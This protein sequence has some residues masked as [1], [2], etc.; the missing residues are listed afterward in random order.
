MYL[1]KIPRILSFFFKDVVFYIKESEKIYLTFDDGPFQ[2]TTP[3]ILE[4]LKALNIKAT[5]FCSGKQ[6]NKHFQLFQKI[7]SDGHCIG[8]HGYNHLNGWETQHLDYIKD[9]EKSKSL[10]RSNLFRPP[11]GKLSWKQYLILKKENTIILWDNMPGDFNENGNKQNILNNFQK[12][13]KP[14]SI[15]VLHDNPKSIKNCLCILDSLNIQDSINHKYETLK[16]LLQ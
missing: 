1:K 8:N 10:V 7:I 4:K 3:L 13:L 5:F 14:G 15:I 12:N 11:Y 9:I 2:E 16:C 6:I